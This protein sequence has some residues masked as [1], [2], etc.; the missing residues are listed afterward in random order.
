MIPLYIDLEAAEVTG[1]LADWQGRR[2][3]QQGMLR[4]VHDINAAT[5]KP[6][7]KE[8]LARLFDR[9]WPDFEADVLKPR[10][11]CLSPRNRGGLPKTCSR[12]L[13][14]GCGESSAANLAHSDD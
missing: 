13:L 4:I 11:A 6:V 12:S 5:S 1:P 7:A 3:D 10:R 14:R 2:L 8:A 9:M